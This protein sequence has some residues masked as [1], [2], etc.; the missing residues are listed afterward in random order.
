MDWDEDAD[1]IIGSI[2]FDFKKIIDG[3]YNDMF[4]WKNIYGSPVKTSVLES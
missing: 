2:H 1:E 4:V 3:T